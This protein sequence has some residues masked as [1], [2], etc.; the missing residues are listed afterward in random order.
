MT[1]NVVIS[2]VLLGILVGH[3]VVMRTYG[4]LSLGW[5]V[6]ALVAVELG[7][8]VGIFWV[9]LPGTES[10]PG[11]RW[12]VGVLFLMRAGEGMFLRDMR[13]RQFE[14]PPE[15]AT[16]EELEDLRRRAGEE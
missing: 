11:V 4:L 13:L 8:G 7:I 1:P 10:W 15:A 16:A 2:S 9:G 3:T 5:L 12:A 6:R 14:G